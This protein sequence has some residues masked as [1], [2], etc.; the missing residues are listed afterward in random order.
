MISLFFDLL[1]DSRR[2]RIVICK[3]DEPL[4]PVRPAIENSDP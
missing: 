1:E 4:V 2:K 3:L